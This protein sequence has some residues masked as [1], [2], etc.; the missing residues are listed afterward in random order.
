MIEKRFTLKFHSGYAR[1]ACL[2]VK[3]LTNLHAQIFLEYK[4]NTIS[5]N[6]SVDSVME[7]MSLGIQPG[8]IVKIYAHGIDEKEA[9]KIIADSIN[10]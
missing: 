7:I 6:H 8:S 9:L 3:R 4:D 1:P 5:L 2:L 10:Y